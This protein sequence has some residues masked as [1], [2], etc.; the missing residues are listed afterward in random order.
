MKA[1]IWIIRI[2]AIGLWVLWYANVSALACAFGNLNGTCKVDMPWELR[3]EDLMLLVIVPAL[4]LAL[5]FAL[6]WAVGTALTHQRR[7]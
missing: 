5:V 3:G 1:A 2:I 6:T 7:R 4:L